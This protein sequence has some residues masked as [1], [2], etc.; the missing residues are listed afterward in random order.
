M[1]KLAIVIPYFKIDHFE[2]VLKS[3]CVQ[4]NQNFSLYIGNDASPDD[5]LP[6]LNKYFKPNE[7]QYFDYQENLGGENLS[8][9]W[10]R[11]LKNVTEDWFQILGDDDFIS[12]NLVEEFHKNIINAENSINVIKIRSMLCD[13]DGNITKQL[14]NSFSTGHYSVIDFMIKKFAG[15]LNSSLSEHI[16]RMETYRKVGFA[17]Y[18]LA[19]H[20]DDLLILEASDFK[21]FLFIAE[22]NV[23]VRVYNGSTSGSTDNLLVKKNASISFFYD[24]SVILKERNVSLNKRLLYL[25]SLR[26]NKES[27]EPADLRKIYY[28]NGFMGKTYYQ[29]YLLQLLLKRVLPKRIIRKIQK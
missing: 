24:L 9:Q 11:I 19:W 1:H 21:R 28:S 10:D 22:A 23:F 17:S 8:F 5:P 15:R 20:T 12:A 25:K 16:F 26:N 2:E 29:I 27:L 6:V 4:T 18:D 13:G 7:Y 14:Y 3:L